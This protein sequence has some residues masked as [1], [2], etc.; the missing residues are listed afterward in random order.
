MNKTKILL[1][2][3]VIIIIAGFVLYGVRVSV[4]K[5]VNPN[6]EIITTGEQITST[7]AIYVSETGDEAHVNYYSN[8]TA[9]FTIVGNEEYKDIQFMHAT[10][11]SGARYE[12]IEKGLVL[13]EKSPELTVYKN[14]E[15]LFF[16]RKQEVIAKEQIL[17][18]LPSTTWAWVKTYNGV[19]PATQD[20]SA[21]TP[22][23]KDIFT[24]TFT[25]EG[26]VSGTTDCNSFS[27][28]YSLDEYNKIHFGSFM[29]T[30]MFCEN[31][32]EQEFLSMFKESFV[33][34]SEDELILEND[35][36]I[37]FKRQQNKI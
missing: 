32:Q 23:K 24:I 34:V 5:Q 35:Q 1:I 19:G 10:S 3:V 16:G 13:W 18:V 27:G 31:S 20:M 2:T 15:Q 36:T 12:N 6:I 14:D 8:D 4:Q 7:G 22:I 25:S 21:V 26:R 30:L 28:T 9:L 29:S 17:K 11:A 37:Y 33:Y